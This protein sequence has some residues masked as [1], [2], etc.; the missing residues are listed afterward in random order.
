MGRKKGFSKDKF[1]YG[2]KAEA[3][4]QSTFPMAKKLSKQADFKLG[5]CYIEVGRSRIL[6]RQI[7]VYFRKLF[8]N[9]Q[10]E[11]HKYK[12]MDGKEFLYYFKKNMKDMQLVEPDRFFFVYFTNNLQYFAL[13]TYGD[14]LD[15]ELKRKKNGEYYFNLRVPKLNKT[16]DLYKIIVDKVGLMSGQVEMKKF[17]KNDNIDSKMEEFGFILK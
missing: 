1:M 15:S 8:Y 7:I 2:Y 3:V 4:F 13:F 9:I 6:E 5:D 10:K 16:M 17:N 14:V 11:F 12:E